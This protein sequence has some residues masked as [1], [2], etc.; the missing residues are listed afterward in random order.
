M[1]RH[2]IAHWQIEPKP[3]VDSPIRPYAA[4][5]SAAANSRVI[6]RIS[7]AG[8][9]ET[10]SAY[11]G[12]KS[13]TASRTD[14]SPRT[15]AGGSVELLGEQRVH[16]RQQHGGVG[17]RPDEVVLVGDLGGLG[18]PRVEDDHL[19]AAR[20]AARAAAAGKSGTVIS[21]PLEAIG[22]APKTRK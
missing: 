13:A 11:S 3:W 5:P 7:S 12:V 20:L 1:F 16:H 17:A 6:R 14:S 4:A 21:E 10:A 2:W 19:A 18:A 8:T 15:Y 9:P 22:L